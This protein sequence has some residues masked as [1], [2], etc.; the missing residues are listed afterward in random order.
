MSVMTSSGIKVLKSAY[1]LKMSSLHWVR[2]EGRTIYFLTATISPTPYSSQMCWF[3][4]WTLKWDTWKKKTPPTP[5]TQKPGMTWDE[6]Q[7]TGRQGLPR[8]LSG[9]ESACNAGDAGLIPGLGR[10]PGEGNGYPTP[11]FLPGKS[12]GQRNLAGYNPR[13][14]KESDV[15]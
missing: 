5:N 12:H 10:S 7:L 14:L 8:W 4:P 13:D 6:Q 1:C 11:V 2:Q 9:K 3:R 15:T